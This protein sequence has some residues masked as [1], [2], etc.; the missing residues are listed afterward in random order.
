[1]KS[2]MT[3]SR[4][5][6]GSRGLLAT[7]GDD[8]SAKFERFYY[9]IDTNTHNLLIAFSPMCLCFETQVEMLVGKS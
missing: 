1:M 4:T 2:R 5:A 8:G 6:P 7:L 9:H 3:S